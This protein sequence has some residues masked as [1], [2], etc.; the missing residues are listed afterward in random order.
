MPLL[1]GLQKKKE[2][3]VFLGLPS[4][5]H[6]YDDLHQ[7]KF[8]NYG[9]KYHRRIVSFRQLVP[10]IA[11]LIVAGW[12]QISTPSKKL[13]SGLWCNVP[14]ICKVHSDVKFFYLK[15]FFMDE[16]STC[17]SSFFSSSSIFLLFRR[18]SI[19]FRCTMDLGWSSTL[20]FFSCC[21]IILNRICRKSGYIDQFSDTPLHVQS[22]MCIYN[23]ILY[24]KEVI[25]MWSY[26]WVFG[27]LSVILCSYIYS[28]F[29]NM[30]WQNL[31][32]NWQVC[33]PHKFAKYGC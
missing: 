8:Q 27:W 10:L 7:V 25:E 22:F 29:L 17:S 28:R 11:V 18:S 12:F 1:Y 2:M 4:R 19:T 24:Y 31:V 14:F 6:V 16:S 9:T 23:C 26:C 15:D 3:I 32:G 13:H 30:H 5:I 21:L 20:N 33:I